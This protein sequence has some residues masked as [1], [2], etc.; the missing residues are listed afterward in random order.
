MG[1]TLNRSATKDGVVAYQ[2]SED[3]N[4]FFYLPQRIDAVLGETLTSFKVNYFGINPQPYYAAI[5]GGKMQSVVGG[6]LAG[7]AVPNMTKKQGLA[8]AEEVTKV[9]KVKDPTLVPLNMTDVSVQP[10]FAKNIATL[11]GGSTE[12][13]TKLQFGSQFAYSVGAN[14]SL[15]AEMVGMARPETDL[16]SSNPDFAINIYGTAEFYGDPWVAEIEADLKQVWEYTRTK[17]SGGLSLGWFNVGFDVDSI[18][19]E[20]IKTNVIKITYKEGTGGKEFG[21]QLL[22]TTKTVFEAINKQITSGE[23]MFRFEPN[24]TPQ[25]PTQK[26]SWAASLLPWT[27]SVNTAVMKNFFRQSIKFHETVSFTGLVQVPVNTSMNL[28]MD[29]N[30]QTSQYF[31]DVQ[32]KLSGCI[33]PNKSKGLQGRM[34]TEAKA[35]L[36]KITLYEEMMLAGKITPSQYMELVTFLNTISLTEGVDPKADLAAIAEFESLRFRI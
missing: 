27:L 14:N 23:G 25:Q 1:A 16:G 18:S 3:K 32:D 21:R 29:C 15:F 30:A 9:F 4:R 2:D 11:G 24:P 10:V 20:L 22:E 6:T 7:Q 8:I 36:A 28:A 34:Q 17:V 5:S 19:Q 33:D 35:K 31:N 13:P 26:D 12:F